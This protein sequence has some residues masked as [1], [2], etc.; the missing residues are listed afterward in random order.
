MRDLPCPRGPGSG[1]SREGGVKTNMEIT[2]TLREAEREETLCLDDELRMDE[3]LRRIAAQGSFTA[4]AADCLY[5]RSKNG[6][7][8]L[9]TAQ[10]FRAAGIVSGD[11][12]ELI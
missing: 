1:L 3:V 12:L 10:S 6:G 9:C 7:E 5:L 8:A 4:R 11:E 2:F